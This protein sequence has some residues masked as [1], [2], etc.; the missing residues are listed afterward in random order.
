LFEAEGIER[1]FP[2]WIEDSPQL[3]AENLQ[4]ITHDVAVVPLSVLAA[5]QSERNIH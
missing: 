1:F 4:S 5:E 2:L 3:A